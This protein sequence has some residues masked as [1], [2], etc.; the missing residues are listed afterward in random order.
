[1]KPQETSEQKVK[2]KINTLMLGNCYIFSLFVYLLVAELPF[3][4]PTRHISG[5]PG[6]SEINDIYFTP[7]AFL[8][9]IAFLS[10]FALPIFGLWI[11][12]QKFAFRN[13]SYT[14]ETFRKFRKFSTIFCFIIILITIIQGIWD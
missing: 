9:T 1:M 7:L 5:L 2:R 11:L 10:I 6:I 14:E 12:L 8:Q 13:F 4:L 3:A